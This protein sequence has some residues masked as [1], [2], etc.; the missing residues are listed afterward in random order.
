MKVSVIIPTYNRALLLPRAIISVIGQ[1]FSDWELLVVD[2]GSTDDT[3]AVLQ[4]F[5]HEPR[6]RVLR[7]QNG[8][9]SRARNWGIREARGEWISFLDSDDEWLA[10]KLAKQLEFA[11][12][13]PAVS[14]IHGDEIWI[15]NGVRV[16][17]MNKHRKRGGDIYSD[18]LKLCCVSPSTVMIRKDLFAEV[19]LFRED[20]PVCEDYDLW[21]RISAHHMVG[22]VEDV[23]I[24]KYG[25]HADQLS[26]RY[27]AMD[28][29]RIHAIADRIH[30]DK[31]S[32]EKQRNSMAELKLKCEILLKGYRKHQNLIH[33]DQIFSIYRG[34]KLEPLPKVHSI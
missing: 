29:W 10:D 32:D 2:D 19:G 11:A 8:G 21:L 30:N 26:H 1:S 23:L 27:R 15:R 20:F 22:F 33:Y 4:G 28:F 12:T 16:N 34:S 3:A 9:V 7:S 17:P 13:H 6:L 18:A 25:G 31:L 14:V 24:K 5:A